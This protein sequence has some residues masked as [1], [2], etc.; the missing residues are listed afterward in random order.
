MSVHVN[1][2]N[3]PPVLSNVPALVTI[4]E[5]NAYAFTAAASDVDSPS[6]TFS[7]VGAP[8]GA[9]INPSTGLFTWTPTEAQGGTGVPFVFKVRVSDGTADA[10]ADITINVGEVN[11]PPALAHIGDQTVLLG[12]TLT[13]TATAT[14]ADLPAQ[15]LGYSLTGSVPAGAS[16]NPSTGQF[17]WTPSAAQVGQVY[18]FGVRATDDGPGSLFAEEVI[19]VG[20]GY[21]WTGFLQPI[22]A[23]GSSVFKL[24]RTVP[25]KFALTGPSANITNAVARLYVAK[26]SDNV[27]GTEAASTSAATTGNLFRYS[28]GQYIF[29]L[30]TDG[31]TAGTYQLR[32][33]T[34][35]GVARVVNISL[36]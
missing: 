28:D 5:L 27:A 30:G 17:T 10:D 4:P 2:V 11:Q 33:D 21:T 24:G 23:D 8:A 18:A 13:F 16:I 31:L 15:H 14:D 22:N 9:S 19:H 36:R 35:D 12:D 32:V 26:V 34:G 6:L 1:P 29:N 20:V 3:D 25:V 7:L